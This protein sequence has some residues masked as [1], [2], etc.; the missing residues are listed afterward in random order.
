[1]PKKIYAYGMDGFITPMMKFFAAEGCLPNFS[2]L[3]R[4]GTVNQTLPS[5]PVWTPTNWATLSTGAHTGTHGVSTWQTIVGPNSDGD[6]RG[7]LV[8]S[9]DGRAN[10]AER[11]WNALEHAG[12]KSAAV[13]YPGAHPSGVRLGHVIDGFGHPS[14]NSTDFEVAAAQAYT[15]DV[16]AASDVAMGHDGSAISGPRSVEIIPQLAPADG[17]SNL[18]PSEPPALAT[19]FTVEARAGGDANRFFL[20]A[21][22]N[23]SAGYDRV[24]ICRSRDACDLVAEANLGEWSDWTIENFRIGGRD[25]RSAVRFKLL[26]LSP[27]GSDL[28][29][30]RT[31]VTYADGFTY[32]DNELAAEL[33]R[34]FGPYQ[35]H[36]SMVPY[37]AGMT[38]FDTALEECEYQGL[39]FAD[40]AN[41][42]LH[43]RGCSYF[44][45]HWH[46]YDY[47]NHIHLGD[48]DPVCP[49]FN[50]A[51]QDYYMDY[52]RRAYEVGDRVLGRLYEA[53]DRA[54]SNGDEVYVGILADHGAYPDVRIAN[55]RKFLH[56]EGFL[57][58]REGPDAVAED[59]DNIPHEEVDW[60]K[61]TAYLSKRGFDITINAQPGPAFDE[62]ERKLLTALRTWVDKETGQTPVAIA[63]PKRDAY[64]LGQWGDQCGDV[65]FAWDH[66]YVSGYY[67][68]W[69]GIEGSGNV[70]APLV[71]G[72]HHGGFI[73]TDNGF[74]STFGSFLLAGPGLKREY[75]RPVERLGYIHAVDVVPTIC[76]ILDVEP[77][78]QSQGVVARDLFEGHEMVRERK[79]DPDD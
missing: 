5:F 20:L 78:A 63:L 38:D 51:R 58:L 3:L 36:A 69:L 70:G 54:D 33:I 7:R 25:Q 39:W 64:L 60:G 26:K 45:C 21:L 23:P 27:D 55:I 53:A 79:S 4:E 75:E 74:S 56:D 37:T 19:E 16:S 2:R 72:A 71:Y 35:E 68:Q 10:N 12:L 50:P 24:L 73:P 11:I 66:D 28:K 49:G 65:I 52:F 32:G 57:A 18:P 67:S 48:V 76:H 42:M 47:L 41:F 17:W 15:T 8:D 6:R 34:R 1:M 46:L 30:Y 43:E 14:H 9:F 77:P 13:H 59:Q 61:T 44:T 31:Q 22:G 29:L 62:I 40:V